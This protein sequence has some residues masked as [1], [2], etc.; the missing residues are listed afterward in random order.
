MWP[1]SMF[2]NGWLLVNNE[3]MSKS[4]GNFFTLT[5]IISKYSADAVRMAL[6]NSGD[7]LEPA[8]FEEAVCSKSLLFYPVFLD[9]LKA[10]I[11][12]TEKVDTG[13]EDKRFVDRWFANEMNR[14]VKES[15]VHYD[16]M[17]YREA[18]RTAWYTFCAALD[19]YR[20]VCKAG[21]LLP[22]K[23]LV[24][25]YYEWQLII[26][27][28]ICPHLA[29]H[30]WTLLKKPG[31]VLDAR[32]PQPETEVDASLMSQG[33]Y[34]YD[35]VPHDFIKLLE[36]A[37]KNSTPTSATVYVAKNFPGWKVKILEI[38]RA[39]HK[40]GKL[41]LC[42]QEDMK[43]EVAKGQWKDLMQELMGNAELKSVAKHVGPFAAFKRDEAAGEGPGALE[44]TVKFDEVALL[45][46]NVE[47]LKDKLHM[48][49]SVARVEDAPKDHEQA[50]SNA[51]PGMPAVYY[52]GATG[53]QGGGGD[54]SKGKVAAPAKGKAAAGPVI[55]DMSKL[56][57]LLSRQSYI[58]G[59]PGPTQ[60]DANQLGATPENVDREKFPHVARWRTH[61]SFFKPAVRAQW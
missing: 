32:F 52:A 8:N 54:K 40:Q 10:F 49:V 20:D 34:V 25:R 45:K 37:S 61:I 24:M 60:S 41:P 50:A 56:N 53:A 58:E 6:A 13:K 29:E 16:G 26:V 23:A 47:Y 2:C 14:L 5:D 39:K 18:L 48:D 43:D 22:N 42:T 9:S 36:K 21:K 38:M 33:I 57:E 3:K 35:K 15:K 11:D 17:Y 51:Q 59:G 7:T 55:T 31:S 30:G 46:E 19:R 12:G 28:P 4:K 1:Q 44:E 27:S